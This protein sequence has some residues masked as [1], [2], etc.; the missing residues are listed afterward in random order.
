MH[1]DLTRA[2][3]DLIQDPKNI[4]TWLIFGITFL[5]SKG[6][7]TKGLKKL[8]PNYVPIHNIG[9]SHLLWG[10]FLIWEVHYFIPGGATL[11]AKECKSLSR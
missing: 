7:D 2:I 1:E 8:M 9:E 10:G 3:N 6:R 11:C 5:L 4:P